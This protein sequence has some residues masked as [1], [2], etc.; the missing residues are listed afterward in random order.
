[1]AKR[2]VPLPPLKQR[3][4]ILPNLVTSKYFTQHTM[5]SRIGDIII[6]PAV[7]K[8]LWETEHMWRHLAETG[9]GFGI[10]EFTEDG[11]FNR[12]LFHESSVFV[13]VTPGE[14][15]VAGGLFGPSTLSRER[16]KVA[17]CY[18][19]TKSSHRRLGIGSQM[20]D[21]F[22]GLAQK[23][24]FEGLMVDVLLTNLQF[25]K[26]MKNLGFVICGSLPFCAYVKHH[27]PTDSL[28]CFKDFRNRLKSAL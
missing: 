5:S 3:E 18:I 21:M 20:L 13:A 23:H 8:E 19:G 7:Q 16:D 11:I 4:N 24:N 12:K 15:I 14:K 27:G 25:M 28:L 9:D 6:R 17:T 22:V 26:R 10:D 2:N 1:M